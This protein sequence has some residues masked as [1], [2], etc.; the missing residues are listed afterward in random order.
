MRRV[1]FAIL[2]QMEDLRIRRAI[3]SDAPVI[4]AF[5]AAMARETEHLEL[6]P[7]RLLTG[8]EAVLADPA[9]G[10][11][12][13]A[14]SGGGQVVGQLMITFEWSDWRNGNFWWIQSVYVDA[15][16]RG[17]GVYKRLYEHIRHAAAEAG[18]VCGLRLYVERDNTRAQEVYRR[19]G[20]Q[21]TAYRMFE[22]DFVIGR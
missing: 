12:T 10:F 11:Y 22:V 3:S 1:V 15:P 19:Q 7:I 16:A 8:V 5:N 18:N 2:I 6:D 17:T 21:A 4:A 9:K 20:M 14:E 13:V